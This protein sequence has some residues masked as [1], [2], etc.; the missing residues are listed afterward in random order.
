MFQFDAGTY[1]QT[2]NVYGTDVLTVAGQ[3]SDAIDYVTRMVRDS[4]YTTNAETDD[5][6]RAWLNRFDP[7][8]AQLV[9]QW[10]RTVV[11]Y[12]NG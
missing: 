5:K 8:N 7:N 3:T 9:D 6:A 1:A 4:A 12:Y 2:I 10:I 11:R